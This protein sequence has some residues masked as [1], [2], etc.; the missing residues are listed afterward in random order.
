RR[1]RSTI[2][3]ARDLLSWRLGFVDTVQRF[4]VAVLAAE[5]AGLG[6]PPPKD[7]ARLVNKLEAPSLGDWGRAAY[8]LAAALLSADK[9]LASRPLAELLCTRSSDGA[10]GKSSLV[11]D[12]IE[13][14]D[15]RNDLLHGGTVALPDEGTA[16]RELNEI[17]APLRRIC[18]SMAVLHRFPVFYV[19]SRRERQ[20]G[21]VTATVLGFAGSEPRQVT[22]QD[23]SALNVP[24][25]VP[26]VRG[27][28]GEALL[29][30]PFLVVARQRGTGM[31]ETR[32]LY[33][34]SGDTK[35]FTYSELRSNERTR[36]DL[37]EDG[38]ESGERGTP[39]TRLRNRPPLAGRRENA[40]PA[41]LVELVLGPETTGLPAI[42]G[43]V[44]EGIL[45][46]GAAGIVYAAREVRGNDSVGPLVAL[47]RLDPS[48]AEH[49][50]ER[51]RRE[52]Q[53][54]RR[55]EHPAIVRA[56]DFV[57]NR[58]Q[59]VFL[60]MEYAEG[61][62]L[63]RRIEQGPIP[64]RQAIRI[65]RDV[66]Q[67]LAAAHAANI[68]HR[69]IK[70]SNVIVAPDGTVKLIDFGV[71][72][73]VSDQRLTRTLD[74][75]GTL[76]YAAPE[77]QRGQAEPVSDVYSVGRL[78]WCL[79]RGRLDAHGAPTELPPGLLAIVRRATQT[80]PRDRFRT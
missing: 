72:M 38:E 17:E 43:Y 7:Y 4:L 79:V 63:Q 52:H 53:V 61:E 15:T 75:V 45:G 13:V 67:A 60:L 36:A 2:G 5:H 14:V 26:F 65:V 51:L 20:D 73:A 39:M 28:Q 59:G 30:S 10:W 16:R 8:A 69:D 25:R 55:L 64:Q 70:P 77:Q 6:L 54:L 35:S 78:L 76:D 49:H 46:R 21:T 23:A 80:H 24:E 42:N 37:E 74:A 12:L 33:A 57:D 32:L 68:V 22:I 56:L 31:L 48:V 34:W 50:R 29:L 40:A 1:A 27:E 18:T 41:S 66:L 3:D 11:D 47:K 9:P 19:R 44:I 71:A 62:D 58:T